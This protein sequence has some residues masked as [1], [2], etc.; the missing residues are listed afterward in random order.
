MANL[1]IL[2]AYTGVAY[3]VKFKPPPENKCIRPTVMSPSSL[4]IDFS[5]SNVEI[6][7]RYLETYYIAPSRMPWIHHM[8][9]VPPLAE[10]LDPP[11]V[12]RNRT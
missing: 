10:C 6:N 7:A 3:L 5:P 9:V 1:R 2:V 4:A 8:I 12:I 11:L